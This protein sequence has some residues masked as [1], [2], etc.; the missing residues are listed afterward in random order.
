[1]L[2]LRLATDFRTFA[3]FLIR[4]VASVISDAVELSRFRLPS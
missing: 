1:M 4:S 3:A 2:G